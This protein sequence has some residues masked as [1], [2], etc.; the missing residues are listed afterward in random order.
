MGMRMLDEIVSDAR[1][2]STP[3]VSAPEIKAQPVDAIF[4]HV[5][6]KNAENVVSAVDMP[7]L[8]ADAAAPDIK[9]QPADTI[10]G[11]V[12]PKDV[13]KASPRQT[14]SFFIRLL[15]F[16]ARLAL[17]AFLCVLAWVGGAYYSS[18]HL[19]LGLVTSSQVPEVQQSPQGNDLVSTMQQMT[20]E[21]RAL[22][23][24]VDARSAAQD[25]DQ[26]SQLN[27]AQTATGPAVADLM[28][29]IDKLDADF[30]TKLSQVDEQLASIKQ[31]MSASHAILASRAAQAHKHAKHLHDAFDP[32]RDPTAPG[33][34][35]PLGSQ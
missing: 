14:T 27:R 6:S 16:S 22:K 18:G 1:V 25:A 4:Q 15:R 2:A 3:D 8:R 5:P 23:A 24:S 29:R 11:R 19:P 7:P 17:V 21:I 10:L 20:E 33:L 13:G 34:P 30:T 9:V 28:G 12:P 31:E 32:S 35:H 26:K